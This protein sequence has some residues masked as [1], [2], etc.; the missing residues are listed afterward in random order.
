MR[1][2]LGRGCLWWA[3]LSVVTLFVCDI[4]AD[5]LRPYDHPDRTMGYA[6]DNTAKDLAIYGCVLSLGC[7]I[8]A[9]TPRQRFDGAMGLLLNGALWVF[10]DLMRL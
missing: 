2:A 9:P 10:W 1:A 4:I 3:P 8:V 6:F 5:R 7:F